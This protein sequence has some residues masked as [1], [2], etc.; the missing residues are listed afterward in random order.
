VD[1]SDGNYISASVRL[2]YADASLPEGHDEA[3][4]NLYVSDSPDGPWLL[5]HDHDAERD[6]GTNTLGGTLYDFPVYLAIADGRLR[7]VSP[8]EGRDSS[9]HNGSAALPWQSLPYAIQECAAA[10]DKGI[11]LLVDG[12]VTTGLDISRLEFP[13]PLLIRSRTL[14]G[15]LITSEPDFPALTIRA[16][17]GVVIDGFRIVGP[18]PTKPKGMIN[19]VHLRD[20]ND[21]R[22]VR[23]EEIMIRHCLIEHRA[24]ADAIKIQSG[25]GLEPLYLTGGDRK[26][27]NIKI[28]HCF[29]GGAPGRT[30]DLIDV[31]AADRVTIS[32][33]VLYSTEADATGETALRNMIV[34]KDSRENVVRG[35]KDEAARA[36]LYGRLLDLRKVKLADLPEGSQD[37][38]S[39]DALPGA[40]DVVIERN[41]FARWSATEHGAI[42]RLGEDRVSYLQ[43]IGALIRQNLV[44][45]SGEVLG[46][47]F[48]LGGADARLEHNTVLGSFLGG[49]NGIYFQVAHADTVGELIRGIV[50]LGNL[51]GATEAKEQ[52]SIREKST[53]PDGVL[54][55]GNLMGV[56]GLP[57]APAFDASKLKGKR[58]REVIL[59][60]AAS[61]APAPDSAAIDGRDGFKERDLVGNQRNNSAD[62]GALEVK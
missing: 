46:T 18:A 62:F 37:L 10:W 35:V 61:T 4:L 28:E 57:A 45:G 56:T 53:A 48:Q 22:G 16:T 34:V 19:T 51:F 39:Q 52:Y 30:D 14:H 36:E 5:I 42:V 3:E 9:A 7:F 17:R 25:L 13:L 49:T 41:V 26:P 47:V 38:D 55:D 29:I 27:T 12:D 31:N 50:V 11:T 40:R 24:G 8:T 60:L 21:G 43:T 20:S 6:P 44:L 1:R 58:T 33:N 59:P 23:A 32:G 2:Q 15:S 54:M